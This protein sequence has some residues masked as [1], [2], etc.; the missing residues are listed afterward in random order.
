LSEQ[1]KRE[2]RHAH[3]SI[4]LAV[5]LLVTSAILFHDNEDAMTAG[6]VVA[7]VA[8][9]GLF[10]FLDIREYRMGKSRSHDYQDSD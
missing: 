4:A 3:L 8:C 6:G 5:V 1:T 2:F 7:F 10:F 9:F